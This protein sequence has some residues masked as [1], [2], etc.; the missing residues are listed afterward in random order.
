MEYTNYELK[1]KHVDDGQNVYIKVVSAG[2]VLYVGKISE[3]ANAQG[4]YD[5]IL[6]G[7]STLALDKIRDNDKNYLDSDLKVMLDALDYMV[8]LDKLM[9][10]KDV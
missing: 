5:L 6:D 4:L 7:L 8:Y 10:G 1:F 2:K 3:K 9:K